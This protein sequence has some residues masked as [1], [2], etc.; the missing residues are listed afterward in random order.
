MA[1]SEGVKKT[2]APTSVSP[3][4]SVGPSR[5]RVAS[6]AQSRASVRHG[7]ATKS[8]SSDQVEIVHIDSDDSDVEV[9]EHLVTFAQRAK[10]ADRRPKRRAS[11]GQG[12]SDAHLNGAQSRS[13]ASPASSGNV[14]NG[15]KRK[16]ISAETRSPK[17]RASPAVNQ[18]AALIELSNGAHMDSDGVVVVD[19][20]EA[21]TPR[22][23]SPEMEQR[24][25]F[26]AE[27]DEPTYKA[28]SMSRHSSSRSVKA[29]TE[30][31][32]VQGSSKDLNTGGADASTLCPMC[33][34]SL[35][36]LSD[37]KREAHVN[38]CL[39]GAKP[40]ASKGGFFAPLSSLF[41]S[42]PSQNDSK[43]S[44]S[45]TLP[46]KKRQPT[47]EKARKPLSILPSFSLPSAP[48]MTPS[49]PNAFTALMSGN[50]ETKQW[51]E[52]EAADKRKGRVAKG[53]V[54]QVP[55][56][57]WIEGMEI[58]VDAFRYDKIEGC[59]AYFLSHAHSDHYQQMNE[60]WCHGPIYCSITTANL[61]KL[62]LKVKDEWVHPL[63]MDQTVQVHGIDVTLIDANHC[64]GSVLFLFEGP[65]TDPKSSWSKTPKRIF[66]YLHCGDFRASPQHINHP[67]MQGKKMDAVY[68]DTTYLDPK[69]CFPP[70]EL[71]I[72]ACAQL[73]RERVLDGNEDALHR[74]GGEQHVKQIDAMKGWLREGK[75]KKEEIQD[76]DLKLENVKDEVKDEAGSDEADLKGGLDCD[77]GG[78]DFDEDAEAAMLECERVDEV[79]Q[80][81]L[82]AADDVDDMEAVVSEEV[83]A[84]DSGD[85]APKSEPEDEALPYEVADDSEALPVGVLDD[86]PDVEDD[87]LSERFL[88]VVGTYSIGKERIVKGIARALQTKVYCDERKL[89]IML[90]QD[91]PE[92]HNMMTRNP[93]EAQV[94][95]VWLQEIKGDSLADYLG[96]YHAKHV[97]GG[98]TRLIGLRPTGW[99]YKSE[100]KE[101]LPAISKILERE[102]RRT[103]TSAGL[104]PQ[105]DSTWRCMAFGCP[106]SE[107]SSFYE[108][109]C[110][111]LS[112]DYVKM[113]PTVNVHSANSRA[114][115]KDWMTRWTQEKKRRADLRIPRMVP[116]RS[117]YYW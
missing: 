36:A 116:P 71:V 45:A 29:I 70:Q 47:P 103:F 27:T 63:P 49:M 115:M 59:K 57:K 106:Y 19:G 61:I 43:T 96:K 66:R 58:T 13:R 79:A 89:S 110:F 52:A 11:N 75:M 25:L 62:K 17:R 35:S 30:A 21:T 10:V 102:K 4:G 94:H 8:S 104:Y 42:K 18:D 12:G 88:V 16:L 28:P 37:K 105:R 39:D 80:V 68:L 97:D 109:T 2:K 56:Y 48:S 26:R 81:D 5:S 53:Q 24:P 84:P 98:F 55:F 31:Q 69:Y 111:A 67:A 23:G 32:A 7:A 40:Q 99:T 50:I 117:P 3:H 34:E 87:K 112:L 73:V 1:A 51:Q 44:A 72:D 85:G 76:L 41:G 14:I 93:L 6:S 33:S 90:A 38:A 108:L 101:K 91:D 54:K 9:V 65:H 113:I 60:R 114:K 15:T 100:S 92:L 82:N 22:A 46:T 77:D 83:T 64:P 20:D 107:H 74:T 86:K 95:M 78:N